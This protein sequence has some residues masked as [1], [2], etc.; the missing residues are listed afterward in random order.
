MIDETQTRGPLAATSETSLTQFNGR[1]HTE[2]ALKMVRAN[3]LDRALRLL[4]EA[5]NLIYG[6]SGDLCSPQAR[7]R[8]TDLLTD[9][10]CELVVER[11]F[12]A[13]LIPSEDV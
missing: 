9:A 12:D 2:Q 6:A 1:K 4:Q 11:A 13:D 10:R 5:Q 8:V 3:R 7:L